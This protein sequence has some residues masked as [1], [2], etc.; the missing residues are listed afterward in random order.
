V[1]KSEERRED[2]APF[3]TTE[4]LSSR[5]GNSTKLESMMNYRD[6]TSP[7]RLP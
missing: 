1:R 4:Q 2:L 6:L 5:Q 3:A 7:H